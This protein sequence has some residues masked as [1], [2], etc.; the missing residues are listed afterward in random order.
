[1]PRDSHAGPTGSALFLYWDRKGVM[2]RFEKNRCWTF[3]LVLCLSV[4]TAVTLSSRARAD[5]NQNVADDGDMRNGGGGGAP[6]AYGD[7]DLPGGYKSRGIGRSGVAGPVT[8]TTQIAGDSRVIHST[9]MWK[10]RMIVAGTWR[11][12]LLPRF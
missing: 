4:S 2:R 1:M 12:F 6:P 8:G 10:V 7:P 5:L 9:M 11:M 3:I